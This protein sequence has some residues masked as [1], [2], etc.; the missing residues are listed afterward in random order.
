[1]VIAII[2]ILASMLLPALSMARE[3]ARRAVCISNLKQVYTAAVLY[4]NDYNNYLPDPGL[5]TD[6]AYDNIVSNWG[7]ARQAHNISLEN[8]AGNPGHSSGWWTLM[9]GTGFDYLSRD[10]TW[11]PP[12]DAATCTRPGRLRETAG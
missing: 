2:G 8:Y 9:D 3:K 5:S 12:W 6:Q 1:M 7:N 10:A 11:C 4:S